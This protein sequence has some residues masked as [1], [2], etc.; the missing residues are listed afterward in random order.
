MKFYFGIL[1]ECFIIDTAETSTSPSKHSKPPHRVPLKLRAQLSSDSRSSQSSQATSTTTESS[2]FDRPSSLSSQQSF[3][4]SPNHASASQGHMITPAMLSSRVPPPASIIAPAKRNEDGFF[5][6][7]KKPK[8]GDVELVDH[9]SEQEEG[10]G[11]NVSFRSK[12]KGTERRE[13]V[14]KD[15]ALQRSRPGRNVVRSPRRKLPN[16]R[17][18]GQNSPS[19]K[20]EATG[21]NNHLT[22]G[23]DFQSNMKRSF[24]YRM[25]TLRAEKPIFVDKIKENSDS[26]D[27]DEEGQGVSKGRYDPPATLVPGP[28]VQNQS[29][30]ILSHQHEFIC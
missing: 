19:P 20:H 28:A 21:H 5:V 7:Q 29:K 26:E 30:S 16:D 17:R 22:T 18:M 24:R 15:G 10:N 25:I 23:N 4:V 12:A 27:E 2:Q 14:V 9:A 8:G 13:F 3:T 6:N 11:G 1:I